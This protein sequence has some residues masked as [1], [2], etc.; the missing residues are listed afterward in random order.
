MYPLIRLETIT[1]GYYQKRQ[2]NPPDERKIGSLKKEP[3]SN[4]RMSWI[5]KLLRKME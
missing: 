3:L 4:Q 2:R 1:L 5:D